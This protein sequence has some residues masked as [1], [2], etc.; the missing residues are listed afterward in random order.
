[1]PACGAED[2]AVG[3][4]PAAPQRPPRRARRPPAETR[5]PQHGQRQGPGEL[6]GKRRSREPA[7][8]P[9][10]RRRRPRTAASVL[11]RA[12]GVGGVRGARARNVPSPLWTT[13][14]LEHGIVVAAA[15][16]GPAVLRR[17]NRRPFGPGE[18]HDPRASTP[19]CRHP[20]KPP[21]PIEACRRTTSRPASARTTD[22]GAASNLHIEGDAQQR[23]PP[24]PGKGRAPRSA[25]PS[26]PA[27]GRR[28]ARSSVL[29]ERSTATATG[30]TA[31]SRAAREP[32]RHAERLA[33]QAIEQRH[34]GKRPGQRLRQVDRPA[35]IAQQPRRRPSGSRRRTGGLSSEM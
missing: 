30:I 28:P 31:S 18:R 22:P 16:I 14:Q 3:E 12:G 7:R 29:L 13:N 15:G 21:A 32:G 10:V 1:M 34:R 19:A 26:P 35:A 25:P 4:G 11:A 9:R 20:G 8:V 33:H 2:D 6:R 5:P 24:P 17:E 23:H 27:T